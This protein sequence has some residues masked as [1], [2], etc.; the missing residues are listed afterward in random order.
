MGSWESRESGEWSASG[1]EGPVL[2][3]KINLVS[4]KHKKKF[5][6]I[7][8]TEAGSRAS[9]SSRYSRA[10]MSNSSMSRASREG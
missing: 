2:K 4:Y 6:P 1:G 8:L 10:S 5:Y 3:I 9:R 7:R